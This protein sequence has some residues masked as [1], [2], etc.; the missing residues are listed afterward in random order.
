[1]QPNVLTFEKAAGGLPT[2]QL[3]TEARNES[4]SAEQ[5]NTVDHLES[6]DL[7]E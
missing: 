2:Q 7:I 3:L 1:M 6:V 5:P 4:T